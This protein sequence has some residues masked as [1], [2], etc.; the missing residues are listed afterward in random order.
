MS[1]LTRF[2][3]LLILLVFLGLSVLSICNVLPIPYV[4]AG[5]L[6]L[7][8]VVFIHDMVQKKHSILRNYPLLGRLRFLFESE[9]SKIQ[10]YAIEDD[11]NGKPINRE[12][13]SDIYQKAKQDTNTVPFGTQLN[14]YAEG[15]EHIN[16]SQY[17]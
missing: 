10:Q 6:I 11:I 5:L 8:I 13:R 17:F 9:R 7:G 3:I 12:R 2:K 16:H 1:H 15:Y 4:L 14:L